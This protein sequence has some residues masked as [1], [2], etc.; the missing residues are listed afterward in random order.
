MALD[1][2]NA[3]TVGQQYTSGGVTWQWDGTKRVVVAPGYVLKAGDTMT[4]DLVISSSAP[5]LCLSKALGHGRG[6]RQIFGRK[7]T[8]FR[9]AMY[10]GD[11]AVESSSNAGSH[12]S[13]I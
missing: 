1:F 13:L 8:A 4:G 12:F 9:W 10:L 6:L 5:A 7:G 11:T 3:P 2:P